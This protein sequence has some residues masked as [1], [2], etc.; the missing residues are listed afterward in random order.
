MKK[1]FVYLF[2]G[3][4]ILG[5]NPDAALNTQT[6]ATSHLRPKSFPV[7]LHKGYSSNIINGEN[8][9]PIVREGKDTIVT[10]HSFPTTSQILKLKPIKLALTNKH[11]EQQSLYTNIKKVKAPIIHRIQGQKQTLAERQ[12]MVTNSKGEAVPIGVP[13][14]LTGKKQLMKFTSLSKAALPH[15]RD[16]ALY[17][18]QVFGAQ[19]GLNSS[20]VYDICRSK[21]GGKWLATYDGISYFDGTSFAHFTPEEGLPN[22]NVRAVLEDSKGNVWFCPKDSGL[23]KYDGDTLTVFNETEGLM[24]NAV[25]NLVEDT[26]GNIWWSTF[27]G[28]TKYDGQNITHYYLGQS[29]YTK[30]YADA[31]GGLWAASYEE[32]VKF[33]GNNLVSYDLN[34]MIPGA[35]VA[36][37]SGD[38]EGNIWFGMHRGGVLKYD[39][40]KFSQYLTDHGLPGKSV[41]TLLQDKAGDIWLGTNKGLVKYRQGKFEVFTTKEGLAGNFIIKIMIDEQQNL[42]LGTYRAGLMK[43]KP[44]SFRHHSLPRENQE[45]MI[46]SFYEDSQGVLWAITRNSGLLKIKNDTVTTISLDNPYINHIAYALTKD[47]QN[48]IWIGVKGGVIKYTPKQCLFYP[49]ISENNYVTT[50]SN[51]AQ[52]NVWIGA[53]RG[54]IKYDGKQFVKYYLPLN[55]RVRDIL[56]DKTGTMWIGTRLGLCSLKD[57]QVVVYTEKE[58]L[59]NSI[60]TSLLEDSKGR[61]WIGTYKGGAMT[62]DG[63][64]FTYYTTKEGLPS[65]YIKS[66]VEDRQGN[67]WLGTEKGLSSVQLQEALNSTNHYSY[68]IINYGQESGLKALDF[69]PRCAIL[70]KHN[71]MWWGTGK[72]VVSLDLNRFKIQKNTPQVHLRQLD[73]NGTFIN[74]RALPDSLKSAITFRKISAFENYPSSPVL[75]HHHRHMKFY[76]AT[77]NAEKPQKV[78]YSYRIKG[79]G[80][81]WSRASEQPLAEYQ[82]LP[83]GKHTLQVKALSE[84]QIWSKPLE[85]TFKITPP[86]W[87]SK[88]FILLYVIGG[89]AFIILYIK[90]R[91]SRLVKTQLLLEKKVEERTL[92]LNE[93]IQQLNQLNVDLH[94]SKTEVIELKE[95]EQKILTSQIRRRENELLLIIKTIN[96]RLYKATAIKDDLFSA[97]KKGCDKGVLSAAKDFSKFL[98]AT[99]NLDILMERIEEK[100]P[101]MLMKIKLTYPDLSANDIKHCLYIKLDLTLKEIAQLHNV[102]V[103]AVKTARNRLKKKMNIPEGTSLKCFIGSEF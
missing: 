2:L 40:K 54:V 53:E 19:E 85:Y 62:F 34:K 98:E 21:R 87:K 63:K 13:L 97:I 14:S 80:K 41:Y 49:V 56:V 27:Q 20:I 15:Y 99:S 100:Y 88:E 81:S 50:L 24:S 16:N 103:S 101:G 23:C 46:R 71:T 60:I 12:E 48:N 82:S 31:E 9:H 39:G 36:T 22:G 78:K 26:Y 74:F 38:R 51:D 29:N 90:W 91:L 94:H 73:V 61:I 68:T 5:C 92:N 35:R 47:K 8:I 7:N 30:L 55:S 44:A 1:I 10:G 6:P 86:F 96:E 83:Y 18:V 45:E 89:I 84:A 3:A 59:S 66:I 69:E 64:T 17:D 43:Y 67:V 58:G 65:N 57:G 11:K 52:N 95:K 37:I 102:S 4:C 42:W 70:D 72:T 28:L 79:L 32:I 77:S 33:D 76:F 25:F 93:A 75:D